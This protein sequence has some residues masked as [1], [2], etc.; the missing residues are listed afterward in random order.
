MVCAYYLDG[1]PIIDLRLSGTARASF[2]PLYIPWL[3]VPPLFLGL[4]PPLPV[5]GLKPVVPS[6]EIDPSLARHQLFEFLPSSYPGITYPLSS[7]FVS[8]AADSPPFFSSSPRLFS[9]FS[10]LDVVLILL[11][12][13]SFVLPHPPA[14]LPSPPLLLFSRPSVVGSAPLSCSPL[15]TPNT[16]SALRPTFQQLPF[17]LFF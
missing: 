17:F 13:Y 9:V 7:L 1:D 15:M 5:V 10:L 16:S 3:P 8:S 2:S 14:L 4:L 12:Y 11:P 6:D